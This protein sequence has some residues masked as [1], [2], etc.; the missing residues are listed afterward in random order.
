MAESTIKVRG[1]VGCAGLWG[2][3]NEGEE[4]E[5]PVDIAESIMRAGYA[6]PVDAEQNEKKDVTPEEESQPKKRSKRATES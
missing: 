4:R 2:N 5:L 3:L 6:E 1:L